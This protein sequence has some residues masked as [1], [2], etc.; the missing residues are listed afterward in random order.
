MRLLFLLLVLLS[1][2]FAQ[3]LVLVVSFPNPPRKLHLLLQSAQEVG[4]EVQGVYLRAEDLKSLQ[5]PEAD[6]YLVDTPPEEIRKALQEKLTGKRLVFLSPPTA[7]DPQVLSKLLPYYSSGGRENFKNMFKAFAGLPAGPPR[8]LP[9]VGFYHPARGVM[10]NLPQ[11]FEKPLLVLFHRSDLVAENTAIVDSIIVQSEREGLPAVGF[12][13]PETEGLRRHLHKLILEGRPLPSV[14][15][16]LRLMYFAYE[17]EKK[18]FE[19]LALPVLQGITYRGR[20]EDWKKNP[21][22]ISVTSIPFHFT[23]PEYMGAIDPTVVGADQP[24]KEPLLHMVE[25][26]VKRA[27]AWRDL[28]S[29]ENSQKKIAIVY[30]NY[31]P[32]ERN[33]LASNLNVIKSLELLLKTAKDRG[34]RVET[35]SERDLQSKLTQMIGLYYSKPVSTDLLDCLSLEEYLN[36]Y[37]SLPE[38]VRKDIESYW[39]RPE[40]DPYLKKGCFTI[41]V[42]KS[43]NFLLLP[44]APR[45][46]DYLRS[47]EIYHSTKIP[48]SHYY[49]AFYLYLQKNSHAILHFGTHG[50]QEWTPGKERGLDLWDYPYLTLGT[51]PVIYPYIVDNVGEAL[52]A[53]RRGRALIISYQTP[54]FAP[55]G[56]YGELEELHQLLHKEAQSEGRLKET[57]RRE[58]AQKAMRANIARDLGYKN[59]TQIL[60]D[61]ESFSEKLHNHIH[62]IA[63]QNVP[64]GLHTFGKTKDAEL[65]ALTILQM[66]GREWIKMWEKEPYEEFMAQPVD[67]IKSSKAFAKVLQCMEG[68]PDAYCE[69]VIDLY[70][71][72]DAG[73][74]LVSLF[75]ALEGRYIPASFGGDPIKNPD[76]L[77][78][79]RNLY[80]FDPQRVPTPQAWKTAVEITDQWLIDY[81]QRHGR[82]PQKV[83]FTLWSV[84]TMRHLGVVEAQVLYLLGVRPRWDDGGRVVGLE[85]IPK[86]E[87]GRPRIDVVVSATGLY[88]DHFPNLM[89]LI[90]QAV[91]LV[92]ELEEEENFVRQN[93][94][95]LMAMLLKKGYPHEQAQRLATIRS[96]SN[97]SGAYGSGLDDA[98]FQTKDKK[99]LSGLF[100]HRMGFAYDEGLHSQK[101]HGL[102]EE[103]LKDTDAVLL[104]RSSNLYGM[105]TTDDPFQYLG[106]LALTVEVLSGRKPEVL[107]ANLRST[108]KV[109]T[110]EE[111]LLQEVRARYL[112]PEYV[113]ALM[114]EGYSGVNELLNTL[115]NLYG[116]QVVAPQV[117]RDPIWKEFR[118]VYL[119][120][121][122]NLGTKKWLRE[123]SS[124]SK[125][126][127]ERLSQGI[128]MAGYGTGRPVVPSSRAGAGSYEPSVRGALLQRVSTIHDVGQIHTLS[129][130]WLLS[131]ILLIPYLAGLFEGLRKR[132]YA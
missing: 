96:F 2:G 3:K 75:S 36:W 19:E 66:L 43:G 31:P 35:Y 94:Q 60:K 54:A 18:A 117:V 83:A 51:K 4:L 62:E 91:R 39:G 45:G 48:P 92:A 132:S 114:K 78:T 110:A 27:K 79:G 105:L 24:L 68:S 12:Y 30:Y 7:G 11:D 102:F 89:N 25:N 81:H 57:I 80:G 32:G 90:N 71:R 20:K 116:W 72:L 10:E 41:P 6:I 126:I 127:E 69:T 111:F 98:V 73:V 120:D 46:M 131:V 53:R 99:K 123:N 61:F 26:L 107:I 42:L 74:E 77:P 37:E 52:N 47:K 130:F 115:N 65:L 38:K 76:S 103:N 86:K 113:K 28:Q 106:G 15:V 93:T 8:E 87:L 129:G 108:A 22:G 21:Q 124:A 84:E 59:T 104:S 119:Q 49:L 82:Y 5:L 85:I 58:I 14:V 70:R 101:V 40:R 23:L 118:E 33:I 125:Q 67:K 97:E 56:T 29:L 13:Y 88:R 44:L 109:Q 95:K 122:Y 1:F 55:S 9:A 100:L 34:Y 16:N 121:K 17:E 64:L 128:T 112:N 63:T 50:T